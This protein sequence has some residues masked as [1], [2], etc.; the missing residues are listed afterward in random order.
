MKSLKTA[1][2]MIE[3]VF[4]IVVLGI[5]SAVAIPRLSGV[6]DDANFAQGKATISSIR[7]AISSERQSSIIRGNS[8]Y[9]VLLDDA[10]SGLHE[11]LFDGNASV[12][13]LQ[14]PVY[15]SNKTGGWMKTSANGINTT[16]DFYVKDSITV[17][18]IYNNGSGVF[19]CNHTDVNCQELTE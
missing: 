9:P 15:S 4:V 12:Q 18:F 8:D 13:I 19:D 2:T 3:L 16:Y 5:L 10:G 6:T 1:F 7:S 17:Q 11:K 14:Y